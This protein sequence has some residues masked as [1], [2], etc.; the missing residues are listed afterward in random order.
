MWLRPNEHCV[1]KNFVNWIVCLRVLQYAP[2]LVCGLVAHT[3]R[4]GYVIAHSTTWEQR[5]P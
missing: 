5:I 4:G 2:L 1:L 3:S